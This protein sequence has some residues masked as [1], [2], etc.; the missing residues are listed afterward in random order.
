MK[1][2]LL[3]TLLACLLPSLVL[4]SEREAIVTDFVRAETDRY[5]LKRIAQTGLGELDHA[6]TAIPI[7]QQRVIRMNRDTLYSSGVFDLTYPLTI[8]LPESEGRYMSLQLINQNHHVVLMRYEPGKITIDR[9]LA[10]TRY[11]YV[12]IRTLVDADNQADVN[13]ANELQDQ[14]KIQQQDQ[15]SVEFPEWSK[16]SLDQLRANIL[17]LAKGLKDSRGVYG[18]QE[19]VDPIKHLIGTAFGWGGLPINDAMYLNRTPDA[20][21]GITPHQLTVAKVPVDGFW[22]I[23]VYGKD[24]FFKENELGAYVINDRNATKNPDGSVTVNFGG[25][26]S[27]PNHLPITPGWNYTV[28][29]YRPKQALL[30]GSWKLGLATVKE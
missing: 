5:M 6:R 25:E 24:G 27:Q 30:N 12:V 2:Y 7:D 16:P 15:G 28:R 11:A 22:S 23:S 17:K 29:M 18:K 1:N 13:I 21:D 26:S 4:A 9:A 14:I 8:T 19:S 3:I 20:N 10:G